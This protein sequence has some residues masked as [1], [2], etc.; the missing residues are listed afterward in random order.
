MNTVKAG[1]LRTWKPRTSLAGVTR[2]DSVPGDLFLVTEVYI[3]RKGHR[4]ARFLPI[5]HRSG[6]QGGAVLAEFV[7]L[8]SETVEDR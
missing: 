3:D 8:R 2:D 4:L 5:G 1:Q 7:R 6:W